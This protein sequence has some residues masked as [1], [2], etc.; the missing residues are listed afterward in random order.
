MKKT[1]IYIGTESIDMAGLEVI[2]GS[3]VVGSSSC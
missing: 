3:H 2:A 1:T